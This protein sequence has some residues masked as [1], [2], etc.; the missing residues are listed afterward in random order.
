MSKIQAIILAGGKGSRLRPYTTV[1]PKPLLPL[2][3][4]PI[5]EIIIRQFKSFDIKNIV[6]STGYLGG[7]IEA[8]FAKGKRW[9]VNIQYIR[10]NR[11]LGTAGAIKLVKDV[12]EDFLVIN[13]DVLSDINFGELIKHH[14]K[15]RNIATI[16]IKE[17]KVKTDFGVI[18]SD[19]HGR[20]I[21]YI[22]KPQH[23]FY[24]STGINI[25][26]K[27]CKSYIQNN[28]S[29]GMPELMLRMKNSGEKVHCFKTKA[30]WLDL[31]RFDD[32]ESAQEVFIKHKKKFLF[33]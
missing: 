31:G 12:E 17:R 23:K 29:I 5:A 4:F 25:L 26:N 13:G 2:G 27:K 32:F 3:E 9:G 1:L 14:K 18:Q 22:E 10:E 15:K 6:I 19:D 28:E 21:D 30:L 16:I 11:P 24:V 33:T 7:L 20:L 8:Y